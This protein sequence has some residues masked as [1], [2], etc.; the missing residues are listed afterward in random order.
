M[1]RLG[2]AV[3]LIA[4]L[5]AGI[6]QAQGWNLSSEDQRRFDSYYERWQEYRQRNDRDQTAS[7]EK[8]MY[9][10]MER[11]RIPRTVPF[12]RIASGGG[13]GGGYGRYR[14]MLSASDQQRFDSYYSRWQQYKASNNREQVIS[15]EKRMQDVMEHYKI[16][17]T[18]PY[19][20][21]ASRGRYERDR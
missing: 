17:L 7:M 5:M 3:V 14:N 9:E 15:M 12:D 8:R 11:Y 18:V 4:T 21:I 2:I 19:D 6:A 10:V 1:K 13:G 16:P 20:A